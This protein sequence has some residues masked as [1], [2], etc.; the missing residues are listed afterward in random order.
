MASLEHFL[1]EPQGFLRSTLLEGEVGQSGE[2]LESYG[3]V[4]R[5]GR[6]DEFSRAQEL[7]L[8]LRQ[9][10]EV[11]VRVPERRTDGGLDQGAAREATFDLGGGRVERLAHAD[12]PTEVLGRSAAQQRM[13]WR[14][15][16][17]SRAKYGSRSARSS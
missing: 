14:V 2:V 5:A 16:S 6:L 15:S 17:E 8:R 11:E 13:R 1:V 12:L 3:P 9:A 7:A 4:N 10:P